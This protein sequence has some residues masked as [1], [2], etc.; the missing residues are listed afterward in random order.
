MFQVDVGFL[1]DNPDEM[2]NIQLKGFLQPIGDGNE[3]IAFPDP[4]RVNLE[5]LN[6][7]A[8]IFARGVVEAT[9]QLTCA[10]CLELFSFKL[11]IPLEEVYYYAGKGEDDWVFFTGEV[12]CLEPEIIKAILLEIP[13][14]AVCR[15]DCRGF[16]PSCGVDLNVEDCSCRQKDIDPRLAILEDFLK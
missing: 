4:V 1:K 16:C 12:I 8:A 3:K 7:E 14:K 5:L 11:E 10:R 9:I 6:V 15:E 2:I 13:M